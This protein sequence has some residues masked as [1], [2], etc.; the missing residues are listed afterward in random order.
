MAML[1]LA[2]T[3]F[4]IIVELKIKS[5]KIER[6]NTY[7][8]LPVFKMG[9][10]AL[11]VSIILLLAIYFATDSIEVVFNLSIYL[12]FCIFGGV[13]YGL[14]LEYQVKRRGGRKIK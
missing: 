1:F 2:A 6:S 9:L 14:F 7:S 8:F 4:I 13:I 11:F 5:G 12:F 10:R 3:V